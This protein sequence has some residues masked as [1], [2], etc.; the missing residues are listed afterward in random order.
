MV[1]RR[2]FGYIPD[3]VDRRDRALGVLRG[4]RFLSVAPQAS[5]D[6]RVSVPEVLD[7][8]D[9]GSCTAQSALGAIRLKHV[10]DGVKEPLLASRLLTYWGTRQYINTTS[11][12]SGGHLRDTFR[13]LNGFG[14]MPEKD[15]VNEHQIQ[16]FRQAPTPLE[17]KRMFDQRD[18]ADGQVEYYRIYDTGSD[19][20]QAIK[21]AISN[22]MPVVFGTDTTKALLDYRKGVLPRP[23]DSSRSTGGHAMYICGYDDKAV[24]IPNSWGNGYGM[25]GFISLS[26]EYIEWEET[27]DIWAVAKAPYFSNLVGGVA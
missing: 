6:F 3:P 15:T 18:K 9:L 10:L 19:R 27:R 8:G 20:R 2:R 23:L 21:R 13:F 26:W 4:T 17:Q 7:Q 24:F 22:K 25:L 14:Y 11:W 16:M 12:D 5:V 1:P